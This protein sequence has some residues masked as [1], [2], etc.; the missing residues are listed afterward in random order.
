MVVMKASLLVVLLVGLKVVR[1]VVD[2]SVEMLE[3]DLVYFLVLR[4]VDG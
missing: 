4:L 1:E 3:F 2:V